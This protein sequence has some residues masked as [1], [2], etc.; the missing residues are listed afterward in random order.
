MWLEQFKGG[1]GEVAAYQARNKTC[2]PAQ[3]CLDHGDVIDS[4]IAQ[5][6]IDKN[7][8]KEGTKAL[9]S[10]H[11]MCALGSSYMKVMWDGGIGMYCRRGTDLEGQAPITLPFGK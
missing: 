11:L 2:Y 3:H 9:R 6:E 4:F 8:A 5:F 1:A 7:N 10:I